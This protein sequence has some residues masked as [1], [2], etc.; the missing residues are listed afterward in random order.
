MAGIEDYL[1]RIRTAIYGKDVRQAI[2]DGIRQCYYDGKAGTTDLEARQRLNTAESNIDSLDARIDQ[3][4][5][6]S[7]E[8]PSAAEVTDARVGADG[9]TY[10]NLGDANRTQFSNLKSDIDCVRTG[11]IYMEPGTY[12]E[13]DP[14]SKVSANA[15]IRS[16][17]KIPV[18]SILS[19]TF[20]SGYSGYGQVFRADGTRLG[21]TGTYVTSITRQ[22]IRTRYGDEAD[23]F[24]FVIRNDATPSA[25][26]SSQVPNVIES[27]IVLYASAL[28][29]EKSI[30][31]YYGANAS[32]NDVT[33]EGIWY[34][35]SV[36]AIADIPTSI[37]DYTFILEVIVQGTVIVQTLKVLANDATMIRYKVGDGAWG[38]WANSLS[39]L[40]I[41]QNRAA[42]VYESLASNL[43]NNMF[44]YV[45][46]SWFTDMLADIGSDVIGFIFTF[47]QK[48]DSVSLVQ[49]I[50]ISAYIG[51]VY[52]RNRV[53]QGWTTWRSIDRPFADFG[54]DYY[55][56]GDSTTYG[57]I[58]GGSGQS[59]HNYP[60]CV[61]QV[62]G[63][64]V[65]NHGVTNQGLIKDWN[66][67]HTNFIENLDMT[68]AKL[69]TV[70][71]AYND[72]AQYSGINFGAY[73]DTEATT[74][75]GKYFTI[76]KEF[77]QKCPD[78]QVILVTGYGYSNGT[79]NPVTKPT[80]V[81]QFT[82]NYTFA[83]GQKTTREMYDTLEA[84]CHLHGWNCVN[85][86]KGTVFNEWNA[87]LL[88][89]DQ[90]HPTDEGYLRYG[91]HLA[92]KI[93]SLYANIK[94]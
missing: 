27:S 53:T 35:S 42:T 61:G 88:I 46:T 91:N 94:E 80:L 4:V 21:F 48:I 72:Y 89:G 69:I 49:Q 18:D 63:M 3:I 10:S 11:K 24:V 23:S 76:M 17:Y 9:K 50:F 6:P 66:A 87:S 56:F 14:V 20:P 1:N 19:I 38:N 55:A 86:A 29:N 65:H 70:G 51:R 67:I 79:T 2:H 5:A 84:M 22:D 33:K 73:D 32:L 15:R 25:D 82:H 47:A 54:A 41:S 16:A 74:F 62:L 75:I 78:A 37:A 60:N 58:G 7:G 31:A 45:N 12:S 28:K 92:A 85:Q 93:S 39:F 64:T 59:E 68:G 77:Q 26:I 83:D 81:D 71:W 13:V 40:Q 57:Q 52:T 36:N 30:V 43:P 8:A 34:G 44:A 90:I